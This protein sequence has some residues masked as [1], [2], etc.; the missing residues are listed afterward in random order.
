MKFLYVDVKDRKIVSLFKTT[1][2]RILKLSAKEVEEQKKKHWPSCSC[3]E[4]VELNEALYAMGRYTQDKPWWR[5][6]I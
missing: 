1:R 5:F 4:V 3:E 6:W 2:G